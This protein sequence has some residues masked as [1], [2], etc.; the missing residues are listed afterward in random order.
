MSGLDLTVAH[1]YLVLD[2]LL[3]LIKALAELL[4]LLRNAERLRQKVE[5]LLGK[6]LLHLG[7]ID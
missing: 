5:V 6:A 7:H 3:A 4:P 2:R 1:Q